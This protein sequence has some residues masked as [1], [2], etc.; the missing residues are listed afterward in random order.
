MYLQPPAH[1]GSSLADFSTLKVEAIH[2]S[3]TS[4]RTRSTQRHIPEDDILQNIF[5]DRLM[6]CCEF[7]VGS[8]EPNSCSI[9]EA[10]ISLVEIKFSAEL[11]IDRGN[12]LNA[13]RGEKSIVQLVQ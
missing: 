9:S 5:I 4:V 8:I 10:Y 1:A 13:L 11:N 3:E 7:S 12:R 2:F 6:N